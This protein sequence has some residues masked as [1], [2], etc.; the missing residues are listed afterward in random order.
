MTTKLSEGATRVPTRVAL[1]T[2]AA[3]PELPVD[4]RLLLEPLAARGVIATIAVWDDPAVDWDAFDLAVLRS[5]WDYSARR[6]EFVAWASTVPRLVNPATVVAWNTDKRYLR[7]LFRAGVPIVPTQWVTPGG[8]RWEPSLDLAQLTRSTEIVVKPAVSASARDTGRYDL[9]SG[10]HRDLAKEHVDRLIAAGRVVMVQPYLPE[11]DRY[12]ETSLIFVGGAFSHA[13]RKGAVLAGP[14]GGHAG[15]P[16]MPRTPTTVELELAART[17]DAA[18][19][20][21]QTE[22]LYARVDVVPGPD[23]TPLLLELEVTEPSLY[24]DQARDAA[25]RLADHIADLAS[26]FARQHR[27]VILDGESEEPAE[28]VRLPNGG[29]RLVLSWR[30]A[31]ELPAAVGPPASDP[32]QGGSIAAPVK[33]AP[34]AP[35]DASRHVD[36][37]AATIVEGELAAQPV[38]EPIAPDH[39]S[40]GPP[41]A[42][43]GPLSDLLPETDASGSGQA[44]RRSSSNGVADAAAEAV[45]PKKASTRKPAR[46]TP[47]AVDPPDGEVDRDNRE[48]PAD[49]DAPI[50]RVMGKRGRGGQFRSPR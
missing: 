23:L 50:V 41:G 24:L 22:L 44:G 11:I 31:S 35:L 32:G 27:P 14:E 21:G 2:C 7:E 6:D 45:A 42:R 47:A 3:F 46:P 34:V 1:I 36:G 38:D 37:S 40:A 48:E 5:P 8:R 20:L 4:E 26:D 9:S 29:R 25:D 19:Q 12:G 17:L 15:E 30:S 49:G 43:R 33:E 16:V 10:P 13:V 28:A 39:V 18:A